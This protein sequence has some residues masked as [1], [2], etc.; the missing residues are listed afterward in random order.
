MIVKKRLK[1][2]TFRLPIEKIR[3]GY[4]T[5]KYFNRTK[6]IL[7]ADSH[8]LEV[9][10]Q[11]FQ[12]VPKA[13]V[14]GTDQALAIL[15][16]GTG[17]YRDGNKADRLFEEFLKLEKKAYA[18]WLRLS[19]IKWNQYEVL[20]R[21]IFEVS[22]KLDS[23]WVS[24]FHKLGIES[25]Y[26]GEEAAARESVMH[27]QGDLAN[28]VHLETLYLGA[29]TDGTMIATNTKD[30]VEAANGKPI[31][32]FGARHQAHESQ[33]GGGYAA[34]L[35]GAKGVSTD[36]QGEYWGSKGLGTIPHA[37][38]AAYNGDTVLATL[39]FAKYI[40]EAE[41]NVISLVDFDND[42]VDTSLSVAQAL[43]G[44]LWG[45]RLDTSGNMI[46]KSLWKDVM[47]KGKSAGN[48]ATGVTPELVWNV[49]RALD[50]KGFK[51]VK[52]VVSGGFNVQKI[53]KFESLGVPADVYGVGGSLHD[54][55]DGKFEYTADVVLPVAKK[56][57][58][59]Q[60]NPRLHKVKT[61][62]L[63]DF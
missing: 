60:P 29:L 47:E 24:C 34:Y 21:R 25:L 35:G 37:L 50:R 43:G 63:A 57:R 13:M 4:K 52:I 32:M 55:R 9:T 30:V 2:N 15:H 62:E 12:K 41:V 36:E 31:L 42:S 28:F 44:K 17:H 14:C 22:Q 61:T 23:L 5:D 3:S 46:D 59:Y 33:S 7:L 45:V 27:V 40:D 54:R 8:H 18:M 11:I 6:Q 53:K 48:K 20:N 10:M 16:V 26:D 1:P 19:Q 49:R 51:K 58:A 38:I 39:K 56:G